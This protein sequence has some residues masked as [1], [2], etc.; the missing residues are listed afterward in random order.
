[1]G[2]TL[3]VFVGGILYWSRS[4]APAAPVMQET[5]QSS[6]TIKGS[7]TEVQMVS[8]LAEA[9]SAKNPDDAVS[10]TGGGSSVGIAALLNK[11]IDLANASRPMSEEERNQAKEKGLT[12]GEFIV[13]RDGLSVIV[14]PDNPIKQITLEELGKIYRGDITN[15]KQIGGSNQSITLYGRQNTSGT[16]GFFRDLVV[17]DDYAASMRSMEGNQAIVDAVKVDPTGIGYVGVG[18]VKD[19]S[20][21]ARTDIK[22]IPVAAD[23][24]SPSIS[25]LDAEAVEQGSYPIFRPIYQYLPAIPTKGSIAAR[26]LEFES[27]TDGQDL[28]SKAGFYPITAQ[29]KETNALLFEQIQ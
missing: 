4:K 24:K 5:V 17:K 28:V 23:A 22:I 3:L 25:P 6:L 20:G 15:W 9:F 27:S 19:E 16:Y 11:E 2:I 14:H 26:F 13:A 8:N 7:D 18:Y 1:M 29:D 21:A 10:V 12:I